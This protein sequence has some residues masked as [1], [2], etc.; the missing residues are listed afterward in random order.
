MIVQ[1][2]L[3]AEWELRVFVIGE[4][5]VGYRV[6]KLDPAQLWVDPEAVRVS[7]TTVPGD[8]AAKLLAL[9]R[10]WRLQVAA[11]DL[12]AVDGD[13]V[14]L[15]VNVNCDWRWFEHRAACTAVS[16]AVHEW[17]RLRFSALESS[18]R[19]RARAG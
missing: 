7:P 4:R 3:P 1:Q 2:Y 16:E 5:V 17:V 11:F 12:L 10:H 6:E 18:L 14:F 13:F 15:E 8:L 19:Y 9:S